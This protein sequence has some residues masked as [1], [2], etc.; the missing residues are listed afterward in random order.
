MSCHSFT[1][2]L[3]TLLAPSWFKPMHCLVSTWVSGQASVLSDLP[4]PVILRGIFKAPK[5]GKLVISCAFSPLPSFSRRLAKFPFVPDGWAIKLSESPFADLMSRQTLS[6]SHWYIFCIGR[7][8]FGRHSNLNPRIHNWLWGV[9]VVETPG[10]LTASECR[11][12]EGRLMVSSYYIILRHCRLACHG[13]TW[14]EQRRRALFWTVSA[15]TL[16]HNASERSQDDVLLIDFLH[17]WTK[18][19]CSDSWVHTEQMFERR[20]PI[21]WLPVTYWKYASK[22]CG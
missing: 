19:K 2:S 16:H 12:F 8:N 5:T 10:S 17:A 11:D 22:V 6:R 7:V 13:R 14:S 4:G 15:T 1:T 9:D 3:D 21:Q 20:C 18:Y